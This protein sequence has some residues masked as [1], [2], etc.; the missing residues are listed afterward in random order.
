MNILPK[1]VDLHKKYYIP[2]LN[3]YMSYLRLMLAS[4]ASIK[5]IYNNWPI[6]LI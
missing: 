6:A 2:I 4:G 5:I 1:K 3:K